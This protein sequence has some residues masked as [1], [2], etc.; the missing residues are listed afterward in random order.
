MSM[1]VKP[2]VTFRAT[3]VRKYSRSPRGLRQI[4]WRDNSEMESD[5]APPSD[6]HSVDETEDD[7]D[8]MLPSP[9]KK[10]KIG[11]AADSLIALREN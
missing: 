5:S 6:S 2:K 3:V 8:M 11:R 10:R 7:N 9:C 4:S 1:K